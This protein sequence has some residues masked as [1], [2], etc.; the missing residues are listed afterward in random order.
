MWERAVEDACK[1]G[2]GSV[3]VRDPGGFDGG[4]V[5]RVYPIRQS[6]CYRLPSRRIHNPLLFLCSST[7]PSL[8][9]TAA[10]TILHL[11]ATNLRVTAFTNLSNRHWH[12]TCTLPSF[13]LN[14]FHPKPGTTS[15]HTFFVIVFLLDFI[16]SFVLR[17]SQSHRIAQTNRSLAPPPP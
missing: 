8:T 14:T 3:N 4:E 13:P 9:T 17:P 10:K 15:C 11:T 2:K 6:L 12:P 1:K 7:A 5:G 16:L